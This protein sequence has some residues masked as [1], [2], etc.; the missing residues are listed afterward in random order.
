MC[1]YA[2]ASNV[3]G[4]CKNIL[5]PERVFS[6]STCP[7]KASVDAWLSSGCAVIETYLGGAMYDVPVAS[8][9]VAYDWIRDLNALYG[10]AMV[11]MSRT[12][13]T[14]APGERTRSQIMWEWFWDQLEKIMES[15]LTYAGATRSSTGGKIYAG[16]I[17][18]ADKQTYESD[19]DRVIP[20]F[21]RGMHD[22]PGTLKPSISTGSQT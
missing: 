2:A 8:G 17:S 1:A 7:N 10:A 5:G 3:A 6:T 9:T 22:F 20:R 16:G 15:D 19:S 4:L 18:I 13:V 21:G 11:E 12:N 14:L